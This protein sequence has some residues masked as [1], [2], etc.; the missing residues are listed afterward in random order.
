[1]SEIILEEKKSTQMST[2][3]MVRIAILAAISFGLTFL[4]LKVPL[5]PSYLSFDLAD[6]PAVF[7]AIVMG[8]VPAIAIQ[9]IKNLLNFLIQGSTTAGVG[10]LANFIMGSAMVI[11]IGLVFKFNKS[12]KSFIVGA[13]LSIIFTTICAC[14]L[15]YFILIPMYATLYFGNDVEAVINMSS[16]IIPFVDTK[17]EVV[18]FSTAPFNIVKGIIVFGV[19]SLLYKFLKNVNFS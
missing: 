13:T 8:P 17:F 5:F 11:P 2:K 14:I 1:M 19:S 4:S 16:I 10:E 18:L 3:V 9:L 12:T 7:A 15:N 6:V